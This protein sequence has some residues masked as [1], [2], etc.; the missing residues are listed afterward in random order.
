MISPNG[1]AHIQLT[2]G[3]VGASRAFYHKLLHE[4]LG[5]AIQYDAPDIFYCIGGRTGVAIR[6]AAPEHRDTHFDQWRIAS[7]ISA[8]ACA[9]GRTSIR[10]MPRWPISAPRSCARLKAV[11]G[12]RDIIPCCSRIPTVSAS[13]AC[14]F[15]AAEISTASKTRR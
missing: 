15:P 12:R 5:M 8:S 14:S 7:I 6:G 3:D 4:T 13:K 10:C 11:P 2:V 1:I 9:R